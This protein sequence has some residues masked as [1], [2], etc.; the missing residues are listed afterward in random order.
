MTR[1]G[2]VIKGWPRRAR[3]SAGS[4]AHHAADARVSATSEANASLGWFGTADVRRH[5]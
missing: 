5:A 2:V 3:N 4:T 1:H